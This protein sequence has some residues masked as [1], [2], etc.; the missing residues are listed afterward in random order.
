LDF[1]NQNICG[2][3][4]IDDCG[5]CEEDQ[6]V[7]CT[8]CKEGFF[9]NYDTCIKCKFDPK[10]CLDC[11][12]DDICTKC[13][14]NHVLRTQVGSGPT[15]KVCVECPTIDGCATCGNNECLTCKDGYY[16]DKG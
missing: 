10:K 13:A 6:G 1:I 8:E 5:I 12:S 2:N 16:L 11:V 3:C 15:T 4:K 14:P 7:G 9:K